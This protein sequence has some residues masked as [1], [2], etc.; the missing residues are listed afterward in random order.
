MRYLL[1]LTLFICSLQTNAARKYS[2][3]F[4]SGT[5][6]HDTYRI[7]AVIRLPDGTLLAFAEGRVKSSDDFGNIDIVLKR[8][9]DNGQTWGPQ[10]TVADYGNLQAGN[11]APVVDLTDPEYPHGR[12]FLFYNTGNN[13]E[14]EVRNGNGCRE[15]WYKT[16]TDGGITWTEA[17][18]ISPQV[19]RPYHPEVNKAYS[20]VED[21]RSYANTPGHAMQFESGRL[22][23]RIVVAANHSQGEPR[24][25]WEDYASHAF[26]TDDHG[27]SFSLSQVIPVPGSN[28]A[29][30]AEISSNRLIIN[31][32]NQKGDIRSRLVAISR[33]GG[34]T[35]DTIWFD[36]NLPDP[37]CEGSIL[38]FRDRS[39]KFILEF[40]NTANSERRDDLTLRISF[41]EGKSW[42]ISIPVDGSGDNKY[43]GDFTAYSDIVVMSANKTG[44]VYE[45]DNYKEIV[46]KT[47]KWR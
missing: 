47:I 41:D 43:E 32:R 46:F 39:G 27:K 23:G 1:I 5:D 3:V 13:H 20:F 31:T 12:I 42:K 11:P 17:V 35:W 14:D 25:D 28:E 29:T 16:S 8:S 7:P 33:N 21:W 40:C 6:G 34:G 4:R 26:F 45:R 10:I 30:A 37:V 44:I 19:H 24:K 22:R 18:N 2:V 36:K 38:S 9:T 15:V